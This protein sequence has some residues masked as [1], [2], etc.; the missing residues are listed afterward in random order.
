MRQMPVAIQGPI[1]MLVM[2]VLALLSAART[3][4][5]EALPPIG[6]MLSILGVV[7]LVL[8]LFGWIREII[9]LLSGWLLLGFGIAHW[10]GG[11]YPEWSATLN[12]LGLG[13]GFFGIFLSG[14]SDQV[15]D[16][17]GKWWPNLPGLFLVI[18]G[19]ILGLETVFGREQVWNALLPLIPLVFAGWTLYLYRQVTTPQRP[20]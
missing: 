10:L 4:F 7:F 2:I 15:L 6:I 9:T 18:L 5:P 16:N 14:R 1:P 8:Y 17:Q 13:G 12:L 3:F 20:S 19:V 11:F